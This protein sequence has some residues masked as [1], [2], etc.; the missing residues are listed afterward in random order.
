[1]NYFPQAGA[2]TSTGIK[3]NIT[4]HDPRNVEQTS[5]WGF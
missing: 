2:K 5:S 1:M 4:P 3:A